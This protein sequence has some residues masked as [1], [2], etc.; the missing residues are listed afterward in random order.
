[1]GI[2]QRE[3]ENHGL[4][5]FVKGYY[6]K[7]LYDYKARLPLF[8]IP[9]MPD[10][11]L[12]DYHEVVQAFDGSGYAIPYICGDDDRSLMDALAAIEALAAGPGP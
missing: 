6:I 8:D 10:F 7:P 5:G 2:R 3:I 9:V 1:M 11:V 12:D 4:D